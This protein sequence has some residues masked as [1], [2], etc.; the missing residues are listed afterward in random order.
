MDLTFEKNVT[1]NVMEKF[2]MQVRDR[3]EA[4]WQT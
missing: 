2:C 4:F 1:L 3:P